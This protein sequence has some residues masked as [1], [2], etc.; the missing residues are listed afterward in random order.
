M[1]A[2]KIM[3]S[4]IRLKNK[5]PLQYIKFYMC[6]RLLLLGNKNLETQNK[7]W[8]WIF[9]VTLYLNSSMTLEYLSSE[10][11]VPCENRNKFN[12]LKI[13]AKIGEIKC[14]FLRHSLFGLPFS[15]FSKRFRWDL[16]SVS[17]KMLRVLDSK[18]SQKKMFSQSSSHLILCLLNSD[19][20]FDI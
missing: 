3:N 13:E 1:W 10:N 14:T 17:V 8:T 19:F 2:F 16:Y 15:M 5:D 11:G 4:I 6:V 7:W 20:K 12:L 9:A 18:T